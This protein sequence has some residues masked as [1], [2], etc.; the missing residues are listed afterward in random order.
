MKDDFLNAKNEIMIVSP[1]AR[2]RRVADVIEWLCEPLTRGVKVKVYT[3]ALSS[4][5]RD[6][7]ALVREC[8]EQLST[9]GCEIIERENIHQ[10]FVLLDKK[11][12]WYGSVNLL[13]YGS[14]EE[15]VMRLEDPEIANELEVTM[16]P[17]TINL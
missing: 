15:S 16:M 10:K 6:D 1:F 11:I 7:I 2:K 14:A 13:S 5:K 3:R 12:V 9:A 17:K 4:Y 8:I